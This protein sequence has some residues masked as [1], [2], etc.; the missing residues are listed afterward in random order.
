MPARLVLEA[1]RPRQ[2]IKNAFVLGGLVFSGEALDLTHELQAW[3]AF[4]AFCLVSGATYLVNDVADAE[5][6]RHNPRTARRP[7]ARGDLAPRTA[8]LAAGLAGG[9]GLALAAAVNWRTLATVGAFIVL[10]LLYSAWLKH[11]LF[12]DVMTIAAG[13]VLRAFAGLVAV[14]VA[15]SPWLLLC[16]G[17][18]AL[19]LGLAKR[20]GEAVALGGTHHPQRPVLEHYSV[21]LLDELIGVVTP[22]I[23]VAYALYTVLGARA[24][25]SMMLTVPFVIYGIFRVLWRIHHRPA[26]TEEPAMVVWRDR[27]LLIC[28]ALWGLTAAVISVAAGQ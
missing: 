6:D 15:I 1:M 2:W 11:V 12:V 8:V 13:F 24:G 19:F 10:Q 9:A 17:L 16:T 5:A 20:R 18:L 26:S 7:V 3:T 25:D 23:L 14:E 4:L 28:I 21:A 22:S 27:P